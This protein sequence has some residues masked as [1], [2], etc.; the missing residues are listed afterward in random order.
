MICV[1]TESN[2]SIIIL[3]VYDKNRIRTFVPGM[4]RGSISGS[5]EKKNIMRLLF[6]YIKSFFEWKRAEY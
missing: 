1:N 5:V 6:K 3:H 4:L 2:K